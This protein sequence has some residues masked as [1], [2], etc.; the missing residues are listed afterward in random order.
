M[1]IFTGIRF[2]VIIFLRFAVVGTLVLVSLIISLFI[3]AIPFPF[4]AI[5]LLFIAFG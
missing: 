4:S 1:M 2:F 3:S 5:L